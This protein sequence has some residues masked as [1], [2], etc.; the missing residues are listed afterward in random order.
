MIKS[1]E[2]RGNENFS[3]SVTFPIAVGC[4]SCMPLEN[5]NASFELHRGVLA[6]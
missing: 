5:G 4:C 1:T 2:V 6:F 3:L